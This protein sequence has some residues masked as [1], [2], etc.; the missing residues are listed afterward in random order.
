MIPNPKVFDQI[1]GIKGDMKGYGITILGAAMVVY[2][3]WSGFVV[4]AQDPFTAMWCWFSACQIR[5]KKSGP[6][7]SRAVQCGLLFFDGPAMYSI[8]VPCSVYSRKEVYLGAFQ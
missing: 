1:C 6:V 8:A 4:Q 3:K 2:T 7:H 5:Q